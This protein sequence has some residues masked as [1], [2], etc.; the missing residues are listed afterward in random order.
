ML[1]ENITSNADQVKSA[2]KY[3]VDIDREAILATVSGYPTRE[4][5]AQNNKQ[6][7][8]PYDNKEQATR[9]ENLKDGIP[10]LNHYYLYLTEGC[11]QAC[12]H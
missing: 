9:P 5:V 1:I 4:Q 7:Q 10:S 3:Q 6:Q 11:N 2:K 8:S 12:Q